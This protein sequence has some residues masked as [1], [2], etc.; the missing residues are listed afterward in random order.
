MS[1]ASQINLVYVDKRSGEV[2]RLSVREET[3]EWIISTRARWEPVIA[4]EK[5]S[6][7]ANNVHQINIKRDKA[8]A[9]RAGNPLSS[10][11]ELLGSVAERWSCR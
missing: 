3:Y 7:R 11:L 6:L 1:Q 9:Q 8:S 2:K 5:V 4:M 10:D